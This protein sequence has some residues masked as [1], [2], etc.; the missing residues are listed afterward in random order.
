MMKKQ[1]KTN[2]KIEKKLN[3]IRE[4]I[5]GVIVV[6]MGIPEK[7]KFDLLN[8]KCLGDLD[9][10]DSEGFE[11]EMTERGAG[12]TEKLEEIVQIPAYIG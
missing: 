5:G 10:E 3:R 8:I 7:G 11:V 9:E 6:Q 2:K 12:K 4:E 1:E